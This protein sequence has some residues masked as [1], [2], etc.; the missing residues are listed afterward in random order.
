MT[1]APHTR[2]F[3]NKVHHVLQ[4]YDPPAAAGLFIL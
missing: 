3:Q 2:N 4:S 1:A